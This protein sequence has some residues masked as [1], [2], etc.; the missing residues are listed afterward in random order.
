MLRN[1]PRCGRLGA[2][3]TRAIGAAAGDPD[4]GFMRSCDGRLEAGEH[5][6]QGIGAPA[7]GD[8]IIAAAPVDP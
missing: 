5:P 3:R 2:C 4:R 7:D 1:G 8:L 6:D